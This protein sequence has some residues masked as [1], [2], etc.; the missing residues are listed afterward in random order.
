MQRAD[1]FPPNIT[2][3]SDTNKSLHLSKSFDEAKECLTT[4]GTFNVIWPVPPTDT[5]KRYGMVLEDGTNPKS[6]GGV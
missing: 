3:P 4:T 2:P 1:T 6:T 5:S